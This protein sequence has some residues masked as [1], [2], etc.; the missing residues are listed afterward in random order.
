MGSASNTEGTQTADERELR[1]IIDT[2]PTTAW[3]A[4]P[5]G[6]CDFLNRR[7]LDYASMTAGQALGWGWVEVIHPADRQRVLEIWQS[8]LASGTEI[9]VGVMRAP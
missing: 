4:R 9:E 6:Y 3:T 8:H 2:I 1:A 5:D 7:W